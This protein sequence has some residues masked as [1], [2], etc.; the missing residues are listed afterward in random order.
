M[1]K[2]VEYLSKP[3]NRSRLVNEKNMSKDVLEMYQSIVP[4]MKGGAAKE[5][6]LLPVENANEEGKKVLALRVHNIG[7]SIV[8]GPSV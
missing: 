5:I 3:H 1:R 4:S 6:C 7:S 2:C 8:E